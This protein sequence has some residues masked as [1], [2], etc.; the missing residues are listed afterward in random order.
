[1]KEDV[2]SQLESTQARLESRQSDV[3]RMRSQNDANAKVVEDL[4]DKVME[5]EKLTIYL[6]NA[7]ADKEDVRSHLPST[8]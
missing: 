6:K 2:Y 3:D 8:F 5:L 4:N 1:M 7:V